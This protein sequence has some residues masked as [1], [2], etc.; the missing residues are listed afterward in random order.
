M[1]IS[2]HSPSTSRTEN[3]QLNDLERFEIES[4]FQT[5]SRIIRYGIIEF[6]FVACCHIMPTQTRARTHQTQNISM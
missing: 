4:Q 1:E 6:A 2:G 5:T 3:K